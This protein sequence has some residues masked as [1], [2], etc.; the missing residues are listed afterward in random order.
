VV[1]KGIDDPTLDEH[2]G[3]QAAA[4]LRTEIELLEG[5]GYPFDE[6]RYLS[7]EQTPVFF[8]SAVNNFGVRE[9]LEAFLRHAP[10]PMPRKAETREVSPLEEQFS[11]VVFK[12]QANMDPAHRDRIAF[13]RVCSGRFNRGMK[14]RHQRTGKDML[15]HN[16]IIFMAQDRAGV[17]EAWPG[18]IIG[19]P[20][21][22]ALRIGDTLCGKEPLRFLGIPHFAPEN[23]RRVVLKNPF[24]AKQ[25]DKG[26]SQLTEEGA[27]QLFRPASGRDLVL[28]AV[29]VLQFDVIAARLAAEYDVDVLLEPMGI[30]AVRWIDSDDKDAFARLEREYASSMVTD[31]DGHPAMTFASEWRL[32]KAV[33]DWP[34]VRFLTAREV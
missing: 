32:E 14:A 4:E 8:G 1:V 34:Q 15:L 24:K 3:A 31:A 11:G 20:N 16:A 12:I 19:I 17:E 25:L 6:K 30:A 33:E 5:A 2:L 26:L 29:G 18:D 7:G 23:F 13:L 21:H 28:G 22:G 10:A 27:I 9:L